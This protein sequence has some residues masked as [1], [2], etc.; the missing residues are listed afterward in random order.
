[1]TVKNKVQTKIKYEYIGRI[2]KCEIVG[3][4]GVLLY[5]YTY[6]VALPCPSIIFG[7]MVFIIA[8]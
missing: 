4:G 6:T 1:M 7:E 5:I 2:E 3:N 8:P